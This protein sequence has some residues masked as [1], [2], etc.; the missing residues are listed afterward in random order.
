MLLKT[1]VPPLVLLEVECVFG[2]IVVANVVVVV[3]AIDVIAVVVV[4]VVASRGV[5]RFGLVV[6][7]GAG[8]PETARVV[9]GSNLGGV[10]RL[11][12]SIVVIRRTAKINH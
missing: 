9:L 8:C 2:R 1:R 10:D 6:N 4:V 3:V 7:A 12:L 11:L 5:L